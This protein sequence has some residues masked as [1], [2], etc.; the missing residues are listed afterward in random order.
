MQVPSA[1][2]C[3]VSKRKDEISGQSRDGLETW[4]KGMKNCTVYEGHAR[5]SAPHTVRIGSETLTAEKIFIN[6]GG[7]ASV[8]EMP[9]LADVRYLTN[10]TIMDVDYLPEHLLVVGG[11]YIGLEFAQMYRRFGSRVTV[12]QRGER[13]VMELDCGAGDTSSSSRGSSFGERSTTVTCAPSRRITC[14]NSSP[15]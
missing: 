9:G 3:G 15:M 5:F 13:I 6:V 4:L 8:P 7:R 12:V 10:S 11:S 1:S 2:T 14:A